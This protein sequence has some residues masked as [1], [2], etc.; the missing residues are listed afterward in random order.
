[1]FLLLSVFFNVL[2][3]ILHGPQIIS[4]EYNMQYIV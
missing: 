4:Y 2:A 1:M 3:C